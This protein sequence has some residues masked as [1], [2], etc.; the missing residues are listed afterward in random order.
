MASR[1][2]A[3]KRR[4]GAEG[5][6]PPPARKYIRALRTEPLRILLPAFEEVKSCQP[7]VAVTEEEE[8]LRSDDGALPHRYDRE[9]CTAPCNVRLQ[10]PPRP[11]DDRRLGVHPCD[12]LTLAISGT[13]APSLAL[14][15][16]SRWAGPL[17]RA[18][19]QPR[20]RRSERR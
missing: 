1:E 12:R 14:V 7:P 20:V 15:C 9:K 13:P 4:Q 10:T 8:D 11:V 3:W 18:V 19:R 2:S 5:F 6:G 17:H 16:C